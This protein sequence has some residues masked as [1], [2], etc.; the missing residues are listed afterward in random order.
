MKECL[1]CGQ[2]RHPPPGAE[3]PG[4]RGRTFRSNRREAKACGH[5]SRAV[6]RC[7]GSLGTCH[8]LSASG[9]KVTV[10]SVEMRQCG[11]KA[12]LDHLSG[13]VGG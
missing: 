12:S 5:R 13:R 2:T 8:F 4:L 1:P 7:R 6:G 3:A 10:E 11:E 9:N